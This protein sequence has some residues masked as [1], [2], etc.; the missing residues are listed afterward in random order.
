MSLIFIFELYRLTIGTLLVLFVPQKCATGDICG[1]LEA[2]QRQDGVSR[3]GLAVNGLTLCIFLVFYA[4]EVK[5]ENK[6]ITYLQTNPTVASDD[7]SVAI[8]INKLQEFRKIAILKVDRYY[9]R[10]G[11]TT[12]VMFTFNSVLSAYVVFFHY[13]DEKSVTAFLTSMLFI[14]MKLFDVYTIAHTPKNIF[15][16]AYMRQKVQFNDVDPDKI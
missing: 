4:I 2:V 3:A 13:L 15:L 10:A 9:Q 8:A 11:Y 5:R 6:L 7:K 16:S 14:T 1:V 12:I